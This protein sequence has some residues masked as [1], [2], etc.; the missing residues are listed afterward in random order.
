MA[1]NRLHSK[2]RWKRLEDCNGI[3]SVF[4]VAVSDIISVFKTMFRW[5]MKNKPQSKNS[6][7]L[8]EKLWDYLGVP[9]LTLFYL[10]PL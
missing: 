1:Q 5:F 10:L 8:S 4:R 3:T 9:I 2:Y 7:K 6:L